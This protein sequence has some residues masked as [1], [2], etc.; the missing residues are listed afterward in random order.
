LQARL[1]DDG[2]VLYAPNAFVME[3]CGSVTCPGN[4]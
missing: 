2:L 4:P 3:K 1:N